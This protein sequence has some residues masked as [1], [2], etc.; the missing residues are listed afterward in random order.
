[1]V[2]PMGQ[3]TFYSIKGGLGGNNFLI[4]ES[5]GDN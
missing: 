4:Y 2:D 5:V 3:L 1:M